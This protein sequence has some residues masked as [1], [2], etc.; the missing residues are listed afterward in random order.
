MSQISCF[1]LKFLILNLFQIMENVSFILLITLAG[2]FQT[3]VAYPSII[4][5]GC[6]FKKNSGSLAKIFSLS[7]T[8]TYF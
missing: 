4:F 7:S 5:D 2:I 1:L 3:G 8:A 6:T